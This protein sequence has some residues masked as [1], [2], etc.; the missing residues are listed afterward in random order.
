MLGCMRR[1]ITLEDDVEAALA[2]LQQE[3]MS[4]KE[5]VNTALREFAARRSRQPKGARYTTPTVDLGQRLRGS[6][7]E[8]GEALAHGEGDDFR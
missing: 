3:G 7:E 1:T 6:V 2:Q 4:L 8:V 5:A